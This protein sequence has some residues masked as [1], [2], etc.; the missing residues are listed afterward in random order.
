MPKSIAGIARS[1]SQVE[2]ALDDLQTNALISPADISVL[3]PESGGTPEV[4]AVKAT[5]APEG[6]T[7]GA[8]TGGAVGGTVGL[9]AG[10][11]TLAIPGLGPFI[12][13]GPIMAALSGAAAG[14]A[15]GGIVGALVGL[16]IPEYEAKAY[17]D[18]IKKGGYLVAVRVQDSDKEDV[19][20][21]TLK[22][23]GLEDISSVSQK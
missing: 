22:R 3:M 12:A 7:T 8:V 14:A 16:G 19:I 21:D 9:L 6:A 15:T 18:R 10:L 11:G 20:R 1:T 2:A 5:K 13:A 23:N 4:G 17:E